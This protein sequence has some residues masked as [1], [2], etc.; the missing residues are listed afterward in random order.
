[1][2]DM[3][4]EVGWSIIQWRHFRYLQNLRY[5]KDAAGV[6]SAIFVRVRFLAGF[7]GRDMMDYYLYTMTFVSSQGLSAEFSKI[8]HR[9]LLM[10]R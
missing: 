2:M 8:F 5:V 10:K 4:F 7:D 6:A 3:S 1:M 9:Y